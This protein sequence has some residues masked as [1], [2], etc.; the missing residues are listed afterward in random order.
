MSAVLVLIYY[1]GNQ[2]VYQALTIP[3]TSIAFCESKKTE[4]IDAI[5]IKDRSVF[6]VKAT[7]VAT[8]PNG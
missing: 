6:V 1:M 7:C 4:F 2:A 8:A 5:N 3:I